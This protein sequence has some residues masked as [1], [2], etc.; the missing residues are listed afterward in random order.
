MTEVSRPAA[1]AVVRYGRVAAI[2]LVVVALVMRVSGAQGWWL[3]PDEGIYFSILTQPTLA[4]FW[5]EVAENAHPP[6]YYVILRA[7]G[8]FTTDFFWYRALSIIASES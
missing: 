2:L 3:N 8:F 1:S 4:A 7:V 5:A 6:L